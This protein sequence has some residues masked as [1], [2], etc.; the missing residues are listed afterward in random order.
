[1]RARSH[2]PDD[3]RARNVLLLGDYRT[4]LTFARSLARAGHRVWLGRNGRIRLGPHSRCVEGVWEFPPPRPDGS[5]V[6]AL[7]RHLA[8]HPKI[9]V[10][11]PLGDVD[12]AAVSARTPGGRE[13]ALPPGVEL[14]MAPAAVV[15]DCLDKTAMCRVAAELSIPQAPFAV[16]EDLEGLHDA[17][18]RIGYPSVVKPTDQLARV[19]GEK[20]LILDGAA[21]LARRLASWPAGNRELLIQGYARGPRHNVQL[22]ARDGELLAFVETKALRTTQADYT[23]YTVEGVSVTPSDELLAYTRTLL[24]HVG[25]GG[26]GCAQFLVD[27]ES[28]A[29]SFLELSPRLG[30]AFA[31]CEACGVDFPRLAV[32]A[33]SGALA[34]PTS[35]PAGRRVAWTYGDLQGLVRALLGRDVGPGAAAAWAAQALRSALRADVHA[36]WSW[37]D[38]K[39]TLAAYLGGVPRHVRK[40]FGRADAPAPGAAG[41]VEQGTE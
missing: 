5:F 9:D 38:P 26:L 41:G 19:N 34:A 28:G 25:F 37:R 24:R 31:V 8:Q 33:L 27:P 13:L 22:L 11:I 4:S 3:G 12:L 29:V 2:A 1:M 35:Y 21:D 18:R 39:P 7:E 16:V 17:A 23:G 14:V 6:P 36:T 30:A 20:A 40:R 32:E 15:R 10:V